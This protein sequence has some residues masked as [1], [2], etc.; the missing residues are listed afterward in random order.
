M[1]TNLRLET[2]RQ[3]RPSGGSSA[4]PPAPKRKNSKPSKPPTQKKVYA[5]LNEDQK[6]A[7]CD[8]LATLPDSKM[9]QVINLLRKRM[10]QFREVC[11]SSKNIFTVCSPFVTN[12]ISHSIP[13]PSKNEEEVELEFQNIPPQV[14]AEMYAF[15][16]KEPRKERA[17]GLDWSDSTGTSEDSDSSFSSG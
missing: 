14:Q 12:G 15:V 9:K 2:H 16:N 7:L 3:K 4:P 5:P 17:G 11:G 10:P 13:I 6:V 1:V 8:V